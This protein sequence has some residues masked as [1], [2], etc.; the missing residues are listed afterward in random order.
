MNKLY[1]NQEDFT[2]RL[3]EFLKSAIPGIRKT[4]LNIIPYII[5]SMIISE[6]CVPADMANVLKDNFSSIQ[7]DSIIKRIRR[8]FSN[9]L[10]KPYDFYQALIKHV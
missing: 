6:S 3:M 4:Q 7:T 1:N 2:S 8:I 10:F 9:K 5:L